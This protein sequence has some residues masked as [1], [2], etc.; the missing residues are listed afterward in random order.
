MRQ[1]DSSPSFSMRVANWSSDRAAIR[2]VRNRVFV[3]EQK[4]P[5]D[6]EWDGLDDQCVHVIVED[7]NRD[8]IGTGRLHPSAKI[9]RMAFN[10]R[11]RDH[12]VGVAI[13]DQLLEL[14]GQ[15]GLEA[16]YLH[17]QT[18]AAGFYAGAGFQPEGVEFEEA[19]IAHRLMRKALDIN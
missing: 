6:I 2:E 19:G 13:L 7:K 17:A 12:G 15:Q 9:G 18:R 4:V 11:W 3:D 1:L 8:A 16:V 5:S 14:A 10:R